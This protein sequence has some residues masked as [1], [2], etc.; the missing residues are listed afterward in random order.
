MKYESRLNDVL[1][2][3]EENYLLPF[4]WQ[5]GNHTERIP[6]QI[7]RIYQSGCRALCVESRPHPD[8]CGEGWWRDMD[9]VFRECQR[10]DMKV[11]ILDDKHFPTGFANEAVK[12]KYPECRAWELV[13]YHVDVIGP[14][15]NAAVMLYP[16]TDEEKLIAVLAVRRSGEDENITGTA[17]DLTEKASNGFV[18][19]DIPDGCWRV[20]LL[21]RSRKGSKPDYVDMISE[22]SSKLMIQEV[23]QPHYEHYSKYFGNTFAGF[24]SD[25]PE[26]GNTFAG[27]HKI[28]PGFYDVRIGQ[29]GLGLPWNEKVLERMERELG[30]DPMPEICQLWYWGDTASEIRLAYMNAVTELYRERFCHP[31]GDWCRSHGVAYIGHIIEDMNNHARLGHGPGHYFRALD[32]QDMSGIDI[33]LHQVMPGMAHYASAAICAGGVADSEFFHYVLAQLGSSL[34][35]LAPQMKGRA[36]CEVF[37]A[38]G[39]G[40]GTSLMKWLMDF[41]LVRGVNHFVPHAFSP[42]YP[43]PDCPPHF[44]AEGHDPQFEGFSA[45]MHYTNK[46]AHLLSGGTHIAPVGILYHAESEWMNEHGSAM[47]TQVPARVLW[48]NHISFDIVWADV[49]SD[50]VLTEDKKLMINGHAFRAL[51]IPA[52]PRLPKPVIGKLTELEKAAFP[53]FYVDRTPEGLSGNPVSLEKL[54]DAA[55]ALGLQEIEVEGDCPL[56]RVFHTVRGQENVYMVFNESSNVCDTTVRLPMKGQYAHLDLASDTMFRAETEDGR[57]RLLLQ[58]GE[59]VVYLFDDESVLQLPEKAEYGEEKEIRPQYDIAIASSED[60]TAYTGYGKTETLF[61]MNSPEHL[62][63]FSGKIRY[64]FE[65]DLPKDFETVQLDLGQVGE[66]AVLSV[67]GKPAGIR[68]AAPYRFDISD[69]VAS[70]SNTVEVTVSNTLVGKVRDN[71]SYFLTLSPSGMM[72]PV[73]LAVKK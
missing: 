27:A 51:V 44:G 13:E 12:K 52:S 32:G 5:H 43:D 24:F 48:D 4:Y 45:L 29:D 8:F 31:I 11:W 26:F 20:F 16:E 46:M 14:K 69:L 39:W 54:A 73:K 25:E 3:R 38:Y 71:F 33:V 61:D 55:I 34:A 56:L 64:R 40:E 66:N 2:G 30:R 62:P 18:Y 9:I 70:G 68:F 17:I 63:G 15:A 10:R 50:A 65:I 6:E 19:F 7:E 49:L 23:Y 35:D 60:L 28:D 37:G 36:M 59:S 22:T 41:L 42:D 47:L 21:Y 67:N 53:I 1:N 57:I 72:G 58:P